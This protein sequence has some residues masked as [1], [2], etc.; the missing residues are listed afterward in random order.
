M[1]WYKT[2][3]LVDKSKWADPDDPRG[4]YVVCMRCS[5]WA[6][7]D[8]ALEQDKRDWDWKYYYEMDPEEQQAVDEAH[9]LGHTGNFRIVQ[10]VCSKCLGKEVAK[11]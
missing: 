1:N 2:S 3:K 10:D 8:S 9:H 5:R 7:D 6:T 4:T 11:V